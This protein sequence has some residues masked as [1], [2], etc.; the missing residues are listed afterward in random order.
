LQVGERD[1]LY[2]HSYLIKPISDCLALQIDI[3]NIFDSK[4]IDEDCHNIEVT[5]WAVNEALCTFVQD[6]GKDLGWKIGQFYVE[7]TPMFDILL[8]T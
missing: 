3:R 5:T 2:K 6:L 1:E 8:D 7:T 4:S